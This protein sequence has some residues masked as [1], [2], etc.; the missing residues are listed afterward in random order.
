MAHPTEGTRRAEVVA[1]AARVF[2][3]HGYRATSMNGLAQAVGLSKAGLYH[4][5]RSKE[6]ILVQLYEDGL[7]QQ[8]EAER[9]I[10]AA[11]LAPDQTLRHLLQERVVHACHNRQLQKIQSEEEAELPAELMGTVRRHRRDRAQLLVDVVNDGMERGQFRPSVSPR[12]AVMTML[13]AV[14]FVYKWYDPEGERSPEQLAEEIAEYLLCGLRP[15]DG[16]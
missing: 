16:S 9:T 10:V 15:V 5:V 14:N 2:A 8:L 4:Y 1:A 3:D 11:G 7:A 13:G 6:E 12:I